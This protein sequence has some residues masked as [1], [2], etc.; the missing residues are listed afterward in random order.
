MK[1][2]ILIMIGIV[3]TTGIL[4]MSI[5]FVHGQT[6]NETSKVPTGRFESK[7]FTIKDLKA[8]YHDGDYEIS[9][10]IKNITNETITGAAITV[11][12]RY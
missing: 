2:R 3:L 8:V 11:V 7:A 1:S 9:G 6:T 4:S 5:N 10:T 12:F